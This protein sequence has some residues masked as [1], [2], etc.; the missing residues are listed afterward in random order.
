MINLEVVRREQPCAYYAS[1][2]D[3]CRWCQML[4]HARGQGN[5]RT[6]CG[7]ACTSMEGW[8]VLGDT[9]PEDV[10]AVDRCQPCYQRIE[11]MK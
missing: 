9:H 11:A 2:F 5:S 7:H 10:S 6:L 8:F 1:V 3:I 4:H